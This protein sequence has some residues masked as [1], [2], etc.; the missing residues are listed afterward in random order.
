MT[1]PQPTD[2]QPQPIQTPPYGGP[3]PKKWP[4]PNPDQK[5][6]TVPTKH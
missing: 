3:F 5:P 2:K 1:V 4:P 6:P